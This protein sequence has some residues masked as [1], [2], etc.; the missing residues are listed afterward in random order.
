MSID[1]PRFCSACATALERRIPSGDDRERLACPQCGRVHYQNPLVVVG[2]VIERGAEV[3]LCR[4][5][6]E[7]AYG[8][9]TTPAGFLELG[10]GMAEGARRETREEA[11]AD[12]EIVAPL[13]SLDLPHI[14]QAYVLF[15]ARMRRPEFDAGA[16]SLEVAF[17]PLE[18]IPWSDLAFPAVHTAL[19]LLVAD[20]ERGVAQVHSGTLRWDGT[21]SRFDPASYALAEH[22]QSPLA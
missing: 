17:V 5:A 9:W 13:L 8:R 20:R 18:A 2:C 15:R 6:I 14:G 4:R 1:P 11:C 16:E 7:P 10:E 21:G 22:L 19:T 12:V 3:L